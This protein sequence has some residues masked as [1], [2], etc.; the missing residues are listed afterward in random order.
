MAKQYPPPLNKQRLLDLREAH[1]GEPA[2][3]ELLWEVA[4]LRRLVF[5]SYQFVHMDDS[6][7]VGHTDHA[8]LRAE[9]KR[10]LEG[11]PVVY[12]GV[13]GLRRFY[14]KAELKPGK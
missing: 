13:P 2:I 7:R 3:E 1:F 12:E 8:Q 10:R 6:D 11:E 5:I 9:L 14:L 4:R